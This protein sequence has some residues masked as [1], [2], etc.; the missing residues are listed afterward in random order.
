MRLAVS[1][2]S[3]IPTSSPSSSRTRQ[4][5]SATAQQQALRAQQT[6]S[7]VHGADAS[8]LRSS[9]LIGSLLPYAFDHKRT[10]ER[11]PGRFQAC[12]SRVAPCAPFPRGG[13][14]Y[15]GEIGPTP[16]PP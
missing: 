2:A 16:A 11:K 5:L 15:R 1:S 4:S 7:T 14:G 12:A 9:T 13:G 10:S 3:R 6:V 8:A